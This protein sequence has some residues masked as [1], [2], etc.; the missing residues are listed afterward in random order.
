MEDDA[1]VAERE[2]S[3]SPSGDLDAP[4]TKSGAV[5]GTP[6]YMSPEQH[7]GRAADERSDQFAFCV[8]LHEALHGEHP[9]KG[10]DPTQLLDNVLAGKVVSEPASRTLTRRC[11]QAIARGLSPLPEDRFPSMEAL[12]GQLAESTGSKR[13][14]SIIVALGLCVLIGSGYALARR[15]SLRGAPLR[16]RR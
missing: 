10:V 11:R 16:P 7:R 1:D 12:L 3:P 9:F 13:R 8:S 6:S 4:L 14:V 15:D 5:L 2:V